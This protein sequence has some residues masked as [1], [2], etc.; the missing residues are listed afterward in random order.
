MSVPALSLKNRIQTAIRGAV[1]ADAATMGLHWI[2]EPAVLLKRAEKKVEAPE[3]ATPPQPNY[4]SSTE[5]PQHY[6]A[7]MSSP[8]GE[9]LIHTSQHVASVGPDHL[10]GAT[11]SKALHKWATF[12]G[13]RPDAAL[14]KF[15]ESYKENNMTDKSEDEYICCGA[16]D[17]QAMV[18][19]KVVPVTCLFA[20]RPELS[21]KLEQ[22]IRAHQNNDMAVE[23]GLASAGLLEAVLLG[24]PTLGEA[25]A[26]CYEH[27]TK[28][29]TKPVQQAYDRARAAAAT[30]DSLEQT[31]LKL[32]HEMMQ[33]EPD[34]PMYD[35]VGRSCSLPQAFV[36]PLA[37][38]Y[39]PDMSYVKAVRENI[40]AAGDNCSRSIFIGAVYGALEGEVPSEWIRQ[41]FHVVDDATRASA[42]QISI[43]RTGIR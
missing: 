15:M 9:L 1:V 17:N 26:M 7:G 31:L 28:H 42:R 23:F 21:D 43:L 5:Y 3:F 25:L 12:F 35:Y 10:S 13:G 16:D 6:K 4:Y 27:E 20:G 11:T 18:Y 14:T 24:A 34:S 33:N 2:Y 19:A 29:G 8:Y 39:K 36:G 22:V 41:C 38:F 37:L 30:G 40:L 32:S